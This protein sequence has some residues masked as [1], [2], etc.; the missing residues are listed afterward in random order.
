MAILINICSRT[1]SQLDTK[2]IY[3]SFNRLQNSAIKISAGDLNTDIFI[4][5][6][7]MLY[8]LALALSKMSKRLK[9]QILEMRK[10]EAY[11]SEFIASV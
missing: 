1:Y 11:R 3:K 8:E 9:S 4:P 2:L 5:K 10:L 6:G 7:G